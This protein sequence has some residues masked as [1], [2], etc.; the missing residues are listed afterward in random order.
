MT[1]RDVHLAAIRVRKLGRQD[2]PQSVPPAPDRFAV[3]AVFSSGV[4]WDPSDYRPLDQGVYR[5][6]AARRDLPS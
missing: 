2:R 3:P 5:D 4:R 6:Y 1:P